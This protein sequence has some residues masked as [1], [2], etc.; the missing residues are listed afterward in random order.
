MLHAQIL[1]KHIQKQ[2]NRELTASSWGRA[3]HELQQDYDS[4]TD[5]EKNYNQVANAKDRI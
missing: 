4:D 5:E 3:E 1:K 2:G